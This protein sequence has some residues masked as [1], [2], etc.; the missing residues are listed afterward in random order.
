MAKTIS[1]LMV[2][3]HQ[4]AREKGFHR[5]QS[6]LDLTTLSYTSLLMRAASRVM[7]ALSALRADLPLMPLVG[8]GLWLGVPARDTE[9]YPSPVAVRWTPLSR[10]FRGGI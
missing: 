5:A 4:M 9:R 8:Y 2:E 1:E 10:H 3:A 7:D 6:E